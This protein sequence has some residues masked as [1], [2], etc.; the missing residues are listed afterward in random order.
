MTFDSL[1]EAN[2]DIWE[3]YGASKLAN[4]LFAQELQRQFTV[5]GSHVISVS[6]HPGGI[7]ET[8]LARHV[9]PE[10]LDGIV[11]ALGP[12]TV[13]KTTSQG[14]YCCFTVYFMLLIQFC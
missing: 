3:R 10:V 9:T 2:Y 5:D 11:I 7:L 13:W 8:D 14:V 4:V 1:G 6:V 12:E